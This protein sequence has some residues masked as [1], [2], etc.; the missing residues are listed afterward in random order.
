MTFELREKHSTQFVFIQVY[1][2]LKHSVRS[3]TVSGIQKPTFILFELNLILKEY[4][5]VQHIISRKYGGNGVF[6]LEAS[7]TFPFL[8]SII[9]SRNH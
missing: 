7:G 5:L 4:K 1:V 9:R 6:F 8:I 3:Y 2:M